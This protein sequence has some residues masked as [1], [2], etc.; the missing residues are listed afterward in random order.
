[1]KR[2]KKIAVV[3]LL[4]ITSVFSFGCH[5]LPRD[6]FTKEELEKF[7]VPDL[8]KLTNNDSSIKINKYV[9]SNFYTTVNEEMYWSYVQEVYTYLSNNFV[10]LGKQGEMISSFFGAAPTYEFI[11]CEELMEFCTEDET[12]ISTYIIYANEFFTEEPN[13]LDFRTI[14]LVYCKESA[15]TLYEYYDGLFH[16]WKK[17]YRTTY[18]LRVSLGIRTA[19]SYII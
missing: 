18:N 9:Y 7:L 3:L 6:F 13:R 1:M 4:I 8:P 17:T 10:Y 12:I 5:S 15:E 19:V 16:L 2:I 14:R 11:P